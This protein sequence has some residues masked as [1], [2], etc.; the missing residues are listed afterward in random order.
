M[1]RI[2]TT[3]SRLAGRGE[4]A[5]V[6]YV[7]AGDLGN[8]LTLELVKGL[9]AS[10]ADMI[11]LGV[12][13]SD[14]VA[15]GPVIQG[16]MARS[17]SS[18]FRL[19]DIFATISSSRSCGLEM[20]IIVMT[21]FNPVMQFG[22]ESFCGRLSEAGADGILVVDLPPEES[23]E[24]DCAAERHGLDL[25]RL[26]TPTTTAERV[27]YILA[28][29][30]GFVY[31]V[32]VA[33]TT[34]VRAELDVVARDVVQRVKSRGSLPVLLGFGISEP[35]HVREAMSFGASGVVEGSRLVSIY[36]KHMHDIAKA[37]SH[38]C[39]HARAMKAATRP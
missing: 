4:G 39:R 27:G 3:L 16:A 18:G 25:I 10:G 26:V 31:A 15:D 9:A 33:G 14:P 5:Y 1:S 2:T 36:S 37:L 23:S 35:S 12:P 34:G 19:K 21:Y 20:P 13:F 17:L 22:V 32:S 38:V 11:E 30:S 6:P 24:L 28:R 8:G 7:C 29:S